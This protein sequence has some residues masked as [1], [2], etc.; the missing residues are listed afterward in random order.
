MRTVPVQL[1][2]RECGSA[3]R[4]TVRGSGT[5]CRHCGRQRYVQV[6]QA[7]EG[8]TGELIDASRH[9]AL[10]RPPQTCTCRACGYTWSS[11]AADGTSLRCPACR[12]P[13]RVRPRREEPATLTPPR[14]TVPTVTPRQRAADPAPPR[15]RQA[16]PHSRQTARQPAALDPMRPGED[17]SG[18][19][20]A[21]A[22]RTAAAIAEQLM[23]KTAPAVP[24]SLR[25]PT[26]ATVTPATVAPAQRAARKSAPAQPAL[27][28]GRPTAGGQCSRPGCAR[29]AQSWVSWQ[30]ASPHPQLPSQGAYCA[31]DRARLTLRPDV[32]VERLPDPA[33]RLR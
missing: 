14:P 13:T 11:R 24:A 5:T 31:S 10:S 22:R 6:N 28:S 29:P 32:R 18:A 33:G 8:P 15:H 25:V 3:F 30:G 27:S 4:T 20:I 9:P 12:H 16:A 23:S 1:V 21:A 2:C 7:W 17:T 26:P 19:G